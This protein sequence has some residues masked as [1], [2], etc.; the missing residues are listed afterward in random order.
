M[1]Y[2]VS[3]FL[4]SRK[5]NIIK[6]SSHGK[7][8]QVWRS[9]SVMSF[10]RY[11]EGSIPGKK[12][13]RPA[14]ED[15]RQVAKKKYDQE[16]R[17]RK[18]LPQWTK[19]RSWLDYDGDKQLMFCNWC[20]NH[21]VD[22]VFVKGTNK[23]K[24]DAVKQHESSKPHQYYQS[25]YLSKS[26]PTEPTESTA[27]QCLLKLKQN[28]FDNLSVRFRNAHF[29]AKFHKSFKDYKLLCQLDKAKGLNIGNAYD[30][31]KAAA[32]FVQ[33]IA[34]VSRDTIYQKIKSSNF[35]SFSCDGSTDF[36][37]DDMESIFIRI[38]TN[39]K[40]EDLF[41]NIGEAESASSQDIFNHIMETFCSAGLKDTIDK[42][43]VG[44]C[45][46]GPS[47]MQGTYFSTFQLLLKKKSISNHRRLQSAII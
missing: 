17:E 24:L 14:S 22:S 33:S 25:R 26:I 11:V 10:L 47:N 44:M 28:D 18:F 37:G 15:E 21:E 8:Q 7:Q 13:K 4:I 9:K 16:S 29:V 1:E 20:R 19:D 41:F 36:T 6:V 2:Y 5:I 27:A 46:D 42:G 43:L 39:G 3:E 32:V 38:C 40:V 45:A 35:I 12:L 30:N 31:D 23:F 34:N